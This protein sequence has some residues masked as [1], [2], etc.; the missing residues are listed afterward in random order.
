MKIRVTVWNEYVHEREYEG[1]RKNYP[2]GI[3]GCIK[4]FLEKNDDIEVRTV[5]LDMPNQA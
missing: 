5:T 4:K 1:I 3:H 2:E